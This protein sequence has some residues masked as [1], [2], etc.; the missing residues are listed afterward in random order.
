MV[1]PW[2]HAYPRLQLPEQARE[3]KPAV[4][5]YVPLGHSSHWVALYPLDHCPAGHQLPLRE[6]MPNPQ[7]APGTEEQAPVHAASCVVALT[8]VPY[9]PGGHMAQSRKE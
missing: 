6:A 5:P 8:A 4:D 7:Y 2:G 3:V 1:D 9:R